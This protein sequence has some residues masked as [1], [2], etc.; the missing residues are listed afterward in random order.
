MEYA[1]HMQGFL[2]PGNDFV[3]K[4]LAIVSIYDNSD[5]KVFVF[6]EPFPWQK[7]PKKYKKL[8]KH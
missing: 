6:Q 7:L 1:V 4:E 2:R 3:I 8:T 5:P